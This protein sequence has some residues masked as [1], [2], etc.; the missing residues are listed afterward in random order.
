MKID[1]M[2]TQILFEEAPS[3]SCSTEIG[4]QEEAI[5]NYR[6]S[7]AMTKILEKYSRNN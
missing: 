2:D 3:E 1:F 4:I 7:A 5:L 6:W